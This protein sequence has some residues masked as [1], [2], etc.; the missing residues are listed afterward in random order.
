M[1]STD[2]LLFTPLKLGKIELS[3]RVALSALT[4][5]RADKDHV[6]TDLMKEYYLQRTSLPGGL[7]IA[8]SASV[9][10]HHGGMPHTSAVWGEEHVQ[11]WKLIVD[12]VHQR[13]CFMYLQLM[14]F[15]RAAQPLAAEEDGFIIKGPSAIPFEGGAMPE[16]MTAEDIKN[17]IEDYVQAAKNAMRAGFDGIELYAANGYL[18]DQFIQDVSNKRADEYGGSIENRNRLV[19][20][21]VQAVSDAIGADRVGIKLSPWSDFQ[22]MRMEEPIPQFT[23]LIKRINN[24]GIGYLNLIESRVSG[25]DYTDG[26]EKLDW[27]WAIWDKAIIATGGYLPETALELVERNPD[28]DIVVAFGRRYVSNPDLP[29][30]IKRGLEL[31][32]YDRSTFYKVG[33]PEGLIDYPFSKEYLALKN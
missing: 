23:D 26:T 12:A 13:G 15:G 22:G 21:I 28:R 32:P 5:L 19:V 8:E 1:A 10:K 27:A 7:L 29:F 33:A 3:H 18:L 11:G 31:N 24:I 2:S 25:V 14:A 16:E 17:T 9:A 30:R 6:A 4:R 20:E